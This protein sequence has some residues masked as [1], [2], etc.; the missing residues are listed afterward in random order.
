VSSALHARAGHG[1]RAEH[2]AATRLTVL[3]ITAPSVVG[4]LEQVVHALASGQTT[5]GHDVHVAAIVGPEAN[6]HPFVRDLEQ[7]GVRVHAP[8]LNTRAYLRERAFIADLCRKIRP[9][10]VHT[11]GYRPDVV[12]GAVARRMKIPTL[13]TVHGFTR[14]PGRG[15]L[16]EWLQRRALCAFNAV[17]AVSR[18]QM[19]EL[20]DAGVPIERIHFIPN[21]WS[22][23]V[24]LLPR[25]P[26]R[27][28]LGI[29]ADA[30]HIGWVGRLS[31]EKGA[32]VLLA[33][34]A[35][36]REMPVVVSFI[37][38]GSEKRELQSQALRT[39]VAAKVKW[40]GV[41]QAASRLFSGFDAFVLSSR[42]EGTPIALFEAMAA[43]TP[44]IATA[45]G[46]VPDVVASSDAL[47]IPSDDPRALAAAIRNVL[48]DRR[49]A[50]QRAS[51]A[52]ERVNGYLPEPWLKRYEAL[53]RQLGTLSKKN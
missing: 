52:R 48:E 11:H 7:I 43:G 39:N 33:A 20:A 22:P 18:P 1:L 51:S 2:G 53:Y 45:V 37:G 6:D 10:V 35:E 30:F 26:A 12:D 25:K 31:P 3:H 28:E 49:A 42:T 29:P 38:D 36:L 8:A 44:I 27:E 46:G 47:L 23:R 9:S 17:V 21:A 4:G 16:Y 24:P 41:T 15:V 13:S 34:L 32:D 5:H 50:A 14:A 40:H 19:A